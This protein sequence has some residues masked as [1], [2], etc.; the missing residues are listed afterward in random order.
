MLPAQLKGVKDRLEAKSSL[1]RTT[2]ED[3][4]LRE[5]NFLDRELT[6]SKLVEAQRTHA[7]KMV[8]GSPDS[9]SCC[10]RAF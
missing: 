4:L 10:G 8:G 2:S 5:L 7:I 1:R 9:C 6:Q 3:E